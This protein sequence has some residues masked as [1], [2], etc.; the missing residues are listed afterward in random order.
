MAE[1]PEM[2]PNGEKVPEKRMHARSLPMVRAPGR[3]SGCRTSL[4]CV[5]G[6]NQLRSKKMRK[7]TA[8]AES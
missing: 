4:P 3:W 2:K 6:H 5:I 8:R 1:A 7:V